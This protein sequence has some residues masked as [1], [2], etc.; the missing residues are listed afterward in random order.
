M[1]VSYCLPVIDDGQQ[2]EESV[3]LYKCVDLIIEIR[4]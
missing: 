4:I 3:W 1:I 2:R